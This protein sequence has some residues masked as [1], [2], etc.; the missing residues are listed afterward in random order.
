MDA[1][2][3]DGLPHRSQRAHD[4]HHPQRRRDPHAAE[5]LGTSWARPLEQTWYVRADAAEIDIQD[6][7]TGLLDADDGL[8]VQSVSDVT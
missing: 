8:I 6:R 7:L 4:R 1:Q 2:E 3:R 5:S